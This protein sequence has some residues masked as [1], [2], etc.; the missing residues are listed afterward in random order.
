MKQIILLIGVCFLVS[1]CS[2]TLPADMHTE[3]K[4]STHQKAPIQAQ[5][6]SITIN[7]YDRSPSEWGEFVSGVK[8]QLDTNQKQIALTFDACGGAHGSG[9]DQAI[10]DYLIEQEI[11]A[12]LFMNKRW[13]EENPDTF[14]Q[15]ANNP[16]FQIENHGTHHKPLSVTGKEAYGINGTKDAQAAYDEVMVN[17]DHISSITGEAPSYFRSGTAHYDD[18]AVDLVEALGLEVVNYDILGDAGGTHSS[19]EVEESLLQARAGS[20]ALL[21][22]N[23]PSSGTSGGVQAAIPQLQNDGF[24]FIKLDQADLK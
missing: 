21:H 22:M 5:D 14:Q 16:L 2:D 6:D 7:H 17:Q 9:Y 10:I 8:T 24:E 4:S 18:V 19:D 12:T 3:I 13:I 15:L 11:P 1:A 23:Q 20:I